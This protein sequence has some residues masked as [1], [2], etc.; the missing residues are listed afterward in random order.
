MACDITA[1]VSS[2]FIKAVNKVGTPIVFRR[3]VSTGGASPYTNPF[4]GA[5]TVQ[6]NASSGASTITLTAPTGN[7]FVEAGDKFTIAGDTT[8]YTASARVLSAS[9]KFTGVTFTPALAANATAGAAVTM[10]FTNDY[11]CKGLA[12]SY[13]SNLIDGSTI[14]VKDLRVQIPITA[15]DNR[16]IPAPTPVDKISIG[17][18]WRS[19]G[20]VMPEYQGEGPAWYTVQ[21]KG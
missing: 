7:Y 21:A 18:A 20:I 11:A 14:T 4:G 16:A 9:G 17:G 12:K 10:T 15:T 3:V 1:K 5:V 13:P 6:A 8:I 19:I 2:G